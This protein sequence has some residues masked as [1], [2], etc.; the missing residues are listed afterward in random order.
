MAL[1][2]CEICVRQATGSNPEDDALIS[3]RYNGYYTAVVSNSVSPGNRYFADF[4]GAYGITQ[5]I[6]P[7]G[8]R[9]AKVAGPNEEVARAGVPLGSFRKTRLI[10]D[11]Q[12]DLYAPAFAGYQPRFKPGHY[13]DYLPPT[14]QDAQQYF[15]DKGRWG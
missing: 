11:I 14:M 7:N 6:A 1:K 13:L 12:W 3:S 4:A 5:I 10:P 15:K 9:L 8:Q 2:G